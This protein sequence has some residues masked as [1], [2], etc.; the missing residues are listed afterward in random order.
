MKYRHLCADK[1]QLCLQDP[2]LVDKR[3]I[4]FA[5]SRGKQPL[6][7]RSAYWCRLWR[8]GV[9]RRRSLLVARPHVSI[10]SCKHHDGGDERE[11]L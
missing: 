1:L 3:S 7:H 6:T 8:R 9:R 11:S 10:A 2:C 5:P 4:G